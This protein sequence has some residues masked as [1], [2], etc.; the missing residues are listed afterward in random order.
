MYNSS[1]LGLMKLGS[2]SSSFALDTKH[3]PG[4]LSAAT[5]E[6]SLQKKNLQNL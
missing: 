6:D 3:L 4:Q 5:L 1:F 2:T